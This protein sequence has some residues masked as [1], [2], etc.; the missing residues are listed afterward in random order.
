M[1]KSLLGFTIVPD[2]GRL[3]VLGLDVGSAARDPRASATCRKATRTF[4]HERGFLRRVRRAGR[5]AGR[6]VQ[7]ARVLFY[8]GLG[9]ARYA[10]SKPIPPAEQRIKLA[11]A[12]GADPDLLFLDEPTGRMD[13]KAR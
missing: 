4:R 5:P 11:Q 10:T 2:G 7:R 1:I 9:E 8:V 6:H 3:R 12:H 13:R